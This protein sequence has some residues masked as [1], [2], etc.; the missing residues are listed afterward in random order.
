[1]APPPVQLRVHVSTAA[2]HQSGGAVETGRV[3]GVDLG[4]ELDVLGDLLRG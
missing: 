2:Q 1:M 3:V 4:V